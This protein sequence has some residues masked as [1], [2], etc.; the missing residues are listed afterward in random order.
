M[1]RRC[2]AKRHIQFLWHFLG[3]G[4]KEKHF[5]ADANH[6]EKEEGHRQP[7]CQRKKKR[8]M[9]EIWCCRHTNWSGTKKRGGARHGAR[10]CWACK[11]GSSYERS[12]LICSSTSD[13]LHDVPIA[14]GRNVIPVPAKHATHCWADQEYIAPPGGWRNFLQLSYETKATFFDADTRQCRSHPHGS[15]QRLTANLS[16]RVGLLSRGR[17]CSFSSTASSKQLLWGLF[18]RVSSG[19]FPH[20]LELKAS[21]S[22]SV[23]VVK[24]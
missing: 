17:K 3:A 19:L 8:T 21:L 2:K 14:T 12:D 9:A 22:T 7:R 11:S 5:E 15:H 24:M 6:F 1:W 4:L 16:N 23:T 18:V 20:C 13:R 10:C